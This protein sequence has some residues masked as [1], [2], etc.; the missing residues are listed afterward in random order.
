MCCLSFS[1]KLEMVFSWSVLR[2]FVCSGGSVSLSAGEM[3]TARSIRFSSSRTL[4]GKS[5]AWSCSMAF[6]GI[7]KILRPK[8]LQ[9]FSTKCVTRGAISSLRWRRGGIWIGNT[10]R[11]KQRSS[12]KVPFSISFSS[13]RL[14]A[15]IRRIFTLI[16][17]LPPKRSNSPSWSTRRSLACSSRGSSPISSKKSVPP[18]ASSK[19]PIFC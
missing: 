13:W 7:C 18:S 6:W 9:N 19:R 3:I 2:F 1:S 12:R 10:C 16:V 8:R 15:A 17:L 4:P 11:R 14:V 5:Q